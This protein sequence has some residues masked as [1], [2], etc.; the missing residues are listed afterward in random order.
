M[1]ATNVQFH[2]DD[3]QVVMEVNAADESDF[4]SDEEGSSDSDKGEDENN[5]NTTTDNESD[6]EDERQSNNNASLVMETMTKVP[7]EYRED[8]DGYSKKQEDELKEIKVT[9]SRFED[10][11]SKDVLIR[12]PEYQIIPESKGLPQ[13][14]GMNQKRGK[15]MEKCIKEKEYDANKKHSSKL[16]NSGESSVTLYQRAVPSENTDVQNIDGEIQFNFKNNRVE[17]EGD[18]LTSSGEMLTSSDEFTPN[19]QKDKQSWT[20][21]NDVPFQI[22]DQFYNKEPR[23]GT[24]RQLTQ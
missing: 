16:S 15:T 3:N 10:M 23:P 6:L 17:G 18:G 24:S 20:V 1:N 4:P 21:M 9:L 8:S 5:L 2:E 22:A 14:S 13:N 11:F 7:P 12:N 19:Q